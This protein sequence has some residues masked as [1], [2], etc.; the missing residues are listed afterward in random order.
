MGSAYPRPHTTTNVFII[1]ST[2]KLINYL[3]QQFISKTFK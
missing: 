2:H 3:L 1:N